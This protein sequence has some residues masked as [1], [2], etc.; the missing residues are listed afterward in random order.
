ME[1]QTNNQGERENLI[2][3]F[4]KILEADNKEK[5]ANFQYLNGENNDLFEYFVKFLVEKEKNCKN[6][7]EKLLF[8]TKQSKGNEER[9]AE[10]GN[11]T[12]AIA[13]KEFENCEHFSDKYYNSTINDTNML[14]SFI[15]DSYNLCVDSCEDEYVNKKIPDKII[16]S[17][18]N[19]CYKYLQM[20]RKVMNELIE[21]S[22]KEF[23]KQIDDLEL[24]ENNAKI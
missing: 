1:S 21:S 5:F 4:N 20:N 19:G 15:K 14:Q 17:C 7:V 6:K 9:K 8:Y 13:E 2:K 18:L 11:E 10:I 16:K 22:M 24:K 12:Y 23:M 3:R